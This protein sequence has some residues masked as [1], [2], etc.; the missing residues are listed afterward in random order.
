M[1]P[2]LKQITSFIMAVS[3]CLTFGGCASNN[4]GNP[5]DQVK[6]PI[7]Q[8]YDEN[9]QQIQSSETKKI[10]ETI[11]QKILD[12]MKKNTSNSFDSIQETAQ[13]TTTYKPAN[14]NMTF[15]EIAD[16][17]AL[18]INRFTWGTVLGVLVALQGSAVPISL[19]LVL[20]GV[21]LAGAFRKDRPKF[22]FFLFM[23]IAGPL[24]FLILIYLPAF[25]WYLN[26][27]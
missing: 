27:N 11:S 21:L 13:N 8:I 1:K 26:N 17:T 22:R 14:K 15:E 16:D 24:F 25:L 2:M 18:K 23:T 12:N 3:M 7:E 6:T 20:F 9:Q 10:K 19:I 5:K 4:S